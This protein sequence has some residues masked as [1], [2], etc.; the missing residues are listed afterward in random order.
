[1]KK[2]SLKVN[3]IFNA[4]YQ[5]LIL[6]VPLI[7]TPYISTVFSSS[8]VGSYSFAYSTV[9]YFCL[10]ADFGFTMY[11]TTVLA[12]VRGNKE[13][14]TKGFWGVFYGKL[15]LDLLLVLL[16]FGLAASGVFYNSNYPVDS[17]IVYLLLGMSICGT[18]CDTTFLFQGK[19]KFVNLCVR[20]L[21]VKIVSTILIF[22]LVKDTGDYLIYV[23]IMACSYLFSGLATLL[24][25]PFMVG[26]PRR[27]PMQDFVNHFK[28][29]FIFFVPSI[30]TTVYTIASKTILGLITGDSSISG[31]YE[32][33]NKIVD[34]ITTVVSSLN[35]IMMSRMAYLYA[36]KDYAQIEIKTSKILQLY[37]ILSL[38]ACFG[39]LVINDFLTLGFLG[40]NFAGSVP[41]IYIL[42][43]KILIIP[44]SG[45]L[46]SIYFIPNN[47]M[48]QRIL[49]LVSGAVFNIVANTVL[50]YFLDSIGA[51]LGCVLTEILVS[52]LFYFG[53]RKTIH[54]RMIQ[55]TWIQCFDA[56]LLMSIVLLVIKS[57]IFGM[58]THLNF[59]LRITYF[60]SAVV[61][62]LI[63]FVLYGSL[64]VLFKQPFVREVLF[65]VLG[66]IRHRKM[67]R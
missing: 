31:Y 44:I 13:E 32:Q 67:K 46:D 63:G 18:L 54:F 57:P 28:G 19:E 15:A 42:G 17:N 41:L 23:T 50:V 7:T 59:N 34:V 39:L 27:V 38:P 43:F 62:G 35:T 58:V 5:V 3:V 8:L 66:K 49:Y 12:K 26:K 64:L 53:A 9:Q 33:A 45:I 48:K 21:I 52:C 36:K 61:L 24:N 51:S 55:K 16:Y 65:N 60:A 30:A 2:Q 1:M 37:C 10:A 40:P 11:G 6:I 22:V 4:I 14:E 47:H 29:A 20:N 25:T 56:A